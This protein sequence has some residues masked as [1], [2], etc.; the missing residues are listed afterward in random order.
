[1]RYPAR[2]SKPE[3]YETARLQADDTRV[4]ADDLISFVEQFPGLDR[5]KGPRKGC[6]G[7]KYAMKLLSGNE[8]HIGKV[9][10]AEFESRREAANSTPSVI[11]VADFLNSRE[12]YRDILQFDGSVPVCTLRTDYYALWDSMYEYTIHRRRAL[13][14]KDGKSPALENGW[15]RHGVRLI[16]RYATW[17]LTGEQDWWADDDGDSD[18]KEV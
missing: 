11:Y 16:L 12:E 1:M 4:T 2:F 5:S 3:A 9:K 14:S 7:L 8:Q 6:T 17:K 13:G 15:F 18:S 10:N